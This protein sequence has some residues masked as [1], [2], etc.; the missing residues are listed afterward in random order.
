MTASIPPP[1]VYVTFVVPD[2]GPRPLPAYLSLNTTQHHA[3]TI[4]HHTNAMQHPAIRPNIIHAPLKSSDTTQA[5]QASAKH[6]PPLLNA[7]DE[8]L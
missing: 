6:H 1:P 2:G 5:L 3:D 7:T 8:F 4:Q